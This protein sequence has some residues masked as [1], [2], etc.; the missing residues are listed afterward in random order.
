[1]GFDLTDEEMR[2]V[3]WPKMELGLFI[4]LKTSQSGVVLGTLAPLIVYGAI[5]RSA[6]PVLQRAVKVGGV[7]GA[8]IGSVI[9][10]TLAYTFMQKKELSSDDCFDR[11]YRLR[12]NRNQV[13]V[14]RAFDLGL[15]TGALIFYSSGQAV[16]GAC[17]FSTSFII[18]TG[19]LNTVGFFGKKEK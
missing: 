5:R 6:F 3:M 17:L 9:G 15:L 7:R 2:E 8:L 10:P 16:F 18:G 4:S 14:D 19:I 1:M 12:Y 11:C 13:R